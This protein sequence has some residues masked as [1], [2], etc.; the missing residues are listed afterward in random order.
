MLPQ[1]LFARPFPLHRINAKPPRFVPPKKSPSRESHGRPRREDAGGLG[2]S[3]FSPNPYFVG[4]YLAGVLARNNIEGTVS[5]GARTIEAFES[6]GRN[7]YPMFWTPFVL[8]RVFAECPTQPFARRPRGHARDKRKESAIWKTPP[9]L[10]GKKSRRQLSVRGGV[11]VCVCVWR[12]QQTVREKTLPK[13]PSLSKKKTERGGVV[14]PKFCRVAST[15]VATASSGAHLAFGRSLTPR[16]RGPKASA[17][18]PC[19]SPCTS[20]LSCTAPSCYP[21][22]R[23]AGAPPRIGSRARRRPW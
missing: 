13:C 19:C 5:G 7:R 14:P 18:R 23:R 3:P 6:L 12:P 11:C 2:G 4:R 22:P 8:H 15:D 9:L 10:R 17:A 20:D 21:G 1:R 16:W